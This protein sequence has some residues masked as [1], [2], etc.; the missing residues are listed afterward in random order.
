MTERSL[1]TLTEAAKAL[2]V[3]EQTIRNWGR[4]GII[5]L[6]RLPGSRHRRVPSAEVER[7]LGQMSRPSVSAGS[8][9]LDVPS[10]DAALMARGQELAARIQEKLAISMVEASLEKVM[11]SLRGRTW[12]P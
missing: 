11:D 5:R 9:H 6:A 12:S 8:V 10:G 1:L 7:L 4:R 2:S 3:H